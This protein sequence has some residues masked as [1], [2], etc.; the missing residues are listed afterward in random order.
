MDELIEK[1]KICI[2]KSPQN[3]NDV[4]SI[5]CS[6]NLLNA[7]IKTDEY[8]EVLSYGIIKPSV[9]KLVESCVTDRDDK[10]TED[11]YYSQ[12]QKCMYIR[13]LGFQFSFHNITITNSIKGFIESILNTPIKWDGIRL[14]PIAKVLFILAE[15]LEK[16]IISDSKIKEFHKALFDVKFYNEIADGEKS[17]DNNELA[18]LITKICENRL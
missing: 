18:S 4:F 10:L 16:R 5:L 17:L 13:S 15:D 6:L 1:A 14:Q 3:Q 11:L 12:Q 7:A 9:S 2:S 8:K